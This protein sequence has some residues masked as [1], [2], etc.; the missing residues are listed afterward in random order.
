MTLFTIAAIQRVEQ[1]DR[2]ARARIRK[3]AEIAGADRGRRDEP[4]LAHGALRQPARFPVE[5]EERFIR[6][7][8]ELGNPHGTADVGADTGCDS[9]AAGSTL[10]PAISS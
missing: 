5:E 10:L 9:G 2:R 1:H 6:A 4:Q 7:V 8:V 3:T